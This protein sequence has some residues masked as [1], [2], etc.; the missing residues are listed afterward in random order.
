MDRAVFGRAIGSSNSRPKAARGKR[1]V[2]KERCNAFASHP[3]ARIHT[4]LVPSD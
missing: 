2:A 4:F 3:R 1:L